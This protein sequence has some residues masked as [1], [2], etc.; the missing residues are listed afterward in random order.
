[1]VPMLLILLTLNPLSKVPIVAYLRVTQADIPRKQAKT[2]FLI[3]WDSSA[4]AF[5][6]TVTLK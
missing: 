5:S 4:I 1:L 2:N 6:M 3:C